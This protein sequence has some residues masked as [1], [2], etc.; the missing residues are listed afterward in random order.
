MN[1]PQ[2]QIQTTPAKLG[3]QID[4]PIQEIE[5]P[6]ATQNIE[7]PA[8]ILEMSTTRPRLSLDSTENRA[9]ID[10]KSTLRRSAENAQYGMQKAL[11]GAGRRAQ[12]G[13]Q[14]MKIENGASLADVIKQSTD[15]PQA[16]I[17]VRFVG[18][19]T[20]LQMSF[21]PGSLD[22]NVRTQKPIVDAQINRPIHN[23]TQ[24]KVSRVMEQY[25]SIDI[26]WKV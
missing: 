13:Q 1:I 18:D 14:L 17:N 22:T 21:S 10:L 23:Y 12:E 6:K 16:D 7:Q 26:D 25:N 8:A 20:K 2:L 5:Q 19:R 11:E 15:R 9:D 24:G 4:K 3:L